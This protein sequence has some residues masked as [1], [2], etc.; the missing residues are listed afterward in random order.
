MRV[1]LTGANGFVG[2]ASTKRLR[3]EGHDVIAITRDEIGNLDSRTEWTP[4]LK[5]VEMVV[6]LAGR[7]HVMHETASDPLAEFR[8][9]N[10]DGTE[11]LARAAIAS[12]V[13][14]MVFISTIKVNG[15]A[16][17][18]TF[19]ATSPAIPQDPY[20]ISKFEAEQALEALRP[21]LEIVILR[22]PLVYGP[23]VRG[24]FI[25]LIELIDR[26]VPLPL[27]SIENRRSLVGLTNLSDAIC[28][29]L[30]AQAGLYFPCDRQDQSTPSLV[31]KIA[32]ALEKPARLFPMHPRLL[33]IAGQLTGKR[34][35]ISR[36]T[37]SLTV[38]GDLPGWSPPRS[39]DA[40]IEHT[41]RWYKE[42]K[43]SSSKFGTAG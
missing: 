31:R 33:M 9:T 19:N 42:S 21:E 26:G 4:H 34:E 32:S 38:D 25:R 37:G 6:H 14:R 10:R 3:S 43:S 35:V 23:K 2:S 15:E 1:L 36:L 29:S 8:K 12:G 16:S 5:N 41:V 40:E 30:Q 11:R 18:H 17:E 20:A 7:A 13:R 28:W 22:P 24:N 27:A 39:I